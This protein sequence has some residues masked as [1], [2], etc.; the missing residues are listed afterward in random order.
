MLGGGRS[1]LQTKRADPRARPLIGLS[2]HLTYG[3]L[4]NDGII[5]QMSQGAAPPLNT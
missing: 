2:L 4:H 1:H 5:V 3:Q